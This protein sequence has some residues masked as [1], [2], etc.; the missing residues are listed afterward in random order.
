MRR[1][2]GLPPATRWPISDF[3][4]HTPRVVSCIPARDAFRL[5]RPACIPPHHRL[6]SCLSYPRPEPPPSHQTR[7]RRPSAPPF[8]A[9]LSPHPAAPPAPAR[10]QAPGIR[11]PPKK[12]FLIP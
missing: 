10:H 7:S 12:P 1:F 4:A 3:P 5:S 11:S 9:F 2:S 6:R 8:P